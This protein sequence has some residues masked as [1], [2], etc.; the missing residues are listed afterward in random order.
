M[1]AECFTPVKLPP[2]ALLPAALMALPPVSDLVLQT[3]QLTCPSPRLQTCVC[4]HP[5]MLLLLPQ[6]LVPLKQGI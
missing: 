1:T 5:F 2:A 6:D 3:L 4:T